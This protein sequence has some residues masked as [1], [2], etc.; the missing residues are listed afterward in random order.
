MNEPRI[1][2]RRDFAEIMASLSAFWGDRDVAHLHHPTAIEE[3]GGSAFV[4]HDSKERVAAYLFGMIVSEKHLGYVHVVAVRSDQRNHGH[5][6]KLYD[7]F[8]ELAAARGCTRIKAI[9]TP[10]NTGSIAF[11][12][13]LDMDAHEVADY[14]G[15]GKSRLVFSR[16]LQQFCKI[17]APPVPELTLRVAT[18]ADV[19][20][21]LT[22]WRLAAED[23][24]RPADRRQ[25]VGGLIARDPDA[26]LLALDGDNIIG[27]VVVGWDGWRAHLYRLAIHPEHRRR[28][29]AGWLLG[30]AEQRLRAAGAIRI[31]A[32]VLNGNVPANMVWSAAG[33]RRQENW[34]R[35]VK[36]L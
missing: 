18:D 33:Y 12:Q 22:F 7:A 25:A 15:P 6:R 8:S 14:A 4:I 10:T 23:S 28:G 36:P 32:M 13:S 31:D 2:T 29:V 24:D 11:H 21:I 17:P 9:T 27:C 34:S 1:A 26:L 30:I 5:G 3:F 35:W 20:A 16:E 19:D